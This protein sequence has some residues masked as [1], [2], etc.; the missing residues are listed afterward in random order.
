MDFEEF[1]K[2]QANVGGTGNPYFSTDT[3]ASLRAMEIKS[4]RLCPRSHEQRG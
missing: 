4:P 3:A 1:E 2:R